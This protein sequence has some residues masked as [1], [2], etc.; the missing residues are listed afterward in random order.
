MCVQNAQFFK[1][2]YQISKKYAKRQKARVRGFKR[3]SRKWSTRKNLLVQVILVRFI[4]YMIAYHSVIRERAD[5][6]MSESN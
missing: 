1:G 3:P 6:V 4:L 5:K 2:A